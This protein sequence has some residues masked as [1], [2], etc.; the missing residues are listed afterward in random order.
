MQRWEDSVTKKQCTTPVDASLDSSDW[1]P[2]ALQ[3]LLDLAHR[4]P[5]EEGAIVA[6]NFGLSI[7]T[8]EIERLRGAS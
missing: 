6:G 3:R 7:T 8:A 2:W 4:L 5:F 1:T